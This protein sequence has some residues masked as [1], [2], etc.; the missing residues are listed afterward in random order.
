MLG[1]S[2][3]GSSVGWGWKSA[4]RMMLVVVVVVVM[5][6]QGR[7]SASRLGGRGDMYC[8]LAAGACVCAWARSLLAGHA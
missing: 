8:I 1:G 4:G 3:A 6:V 2:T 7:R 5:Y